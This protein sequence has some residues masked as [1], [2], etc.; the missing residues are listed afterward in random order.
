MDYEQWKAR[1]AAELERRFGIEA[2]KIPER[3]WQRLY[4][5]NYFPREAAERARR[6][7][8]RRR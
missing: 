3:I 1:A 2:N 6:Y 8:D 5:G 7:F 4:T